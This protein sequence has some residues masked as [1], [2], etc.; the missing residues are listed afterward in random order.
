MLRGEYLDWTFPV[1]DWLTRGSSSLYGTFRPAYGLSGLSLTDQPR[2]WG[3]ATPSP[4]GGTDV[5]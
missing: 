4:V 2:V 1:R 3:S 5:P